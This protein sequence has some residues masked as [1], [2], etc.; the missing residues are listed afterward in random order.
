MSN[1]SPAQ[2]IRDIEQELGNYSSELLQRERW[3]VLNKTDLLL[4]EQLQV[5]RAEIIRELDWQAPVFAI[6]AVTGAGTQD[7]M[8]A[9]MRRLEEIWR[10]EK[11]QPTE[12]ADAPWDPL[13]T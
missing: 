4:D 3:L 8:A 6:S 11:T 7:L 13:Q 9:L 12:T 2:Q 1:I 10:S 5:R